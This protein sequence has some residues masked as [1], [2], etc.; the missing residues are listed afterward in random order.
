MK[1]HLCHAVLVCVFCAG[2]FIAPV[3][4][5]VVG[6]ITNATP[7]YP[8]KQITPGTYATP[9]PTIL[10]E[11]VGPINTPVPAIILVIG[12]FIVLIAIGGLVWRY[13]HPKYVPPED[14]KE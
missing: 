12:V 4:A 13:L 10:P 7:V 11:M 1:I 2:C 9:P 6:N 5:V 3:S 8:V 14:R